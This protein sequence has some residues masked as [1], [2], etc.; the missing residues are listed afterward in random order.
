[1]PRSSRTE[2]Y[3]LLLADDLAP[4]VFR[5]AEQI[6]ARAASQAESHSRESGVDPTKRLLLVFRTSMKWYPSRATKSEATRLGVA[7]Q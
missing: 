3:V 1:M 5:E 2:P 4:G 6:T 7:C